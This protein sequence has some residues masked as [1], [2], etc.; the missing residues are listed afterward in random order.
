M[1]NQLYFLLFVRYPFFL[2]G[3]FWAKLSV[4][5]YPGFKISLFSHPCSGLPGFGAKAPEFGGRYAERP[6]NKYES[7]GEK[8]HPISQLAH[9]RD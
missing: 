8:M 3:H 9:A 1:Q 7:E 6:L 2:S 4:I 5:H